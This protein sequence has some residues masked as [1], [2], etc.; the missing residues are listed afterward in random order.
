MR[1]L[2]ITRYGGP[3]VLQVRE[4]PTPEPGP[5]E[6]RVRTHR[7]GLNFSDLA[8]RLGLYPDAPK[9]PCV[10]GYEVAGVVEA[11]GPGAAR[12]K[13][14]DRVL[15]F[16]RFGGQATHA[17]LPER[18]LL[19]LPD[20][21]SFDEAAAV[22]VNALTAFHLLFHVHWLK[23]GAHLLIHMASGGVG[24]TAIQLA[25]TVPGV[26]TYGTASAAKH[27]FLRQAGLDHPIDYHA[28]DYADEVR[29][30][31]GGKGVDVILDP[32]GPPSWKKGYRLLR[33]M[34]HL[35]CCGWS[36]S[37]SGGKRRLF[38]LA[39]QAAAMPFFNPFSMMNENKTVSGVN[40]GHLWDEEATL[41]GHMQKI[42]ELTVQKK[43]KLH[44]DSVHPLDK[45][46][47]AH[48][49]IAE[50]KNLGKVLF[51]CS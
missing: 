3:E 14:G 37:V 15:G 24:L 46:A 7:A 33:P 27:D 18:R 4:R 20:A 36:G 11:L 5:Q 43:L 16:A 32:L 39:A 8:A 31:T 48:A 30:L 51:D 6:V 29:R 38:S 2:V 35:L 26:V 10:M 47:L 19:P 41:V 45:A 50:H 9:P 22:P 1:E 44:I 42:L 12:F 49:R 23:P 28:V 13:V 17:V 40:L 25:R 21:V 34:G